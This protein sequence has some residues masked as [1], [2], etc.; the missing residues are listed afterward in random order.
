MHPE[1]IVFFAILLAVILLVPPLFER[2]RLPGLVG[3]LVAGVVLGPN[4]LGLLQ[5]DSETMSLLSDIGLVY[6][7]F[8]AGLEINLEQFQA[9]KNRSL[10]FG[11]FTFII[12]LI[13]G[14][15]VGRLFGFGLNASVLIGSLFAS[16]TLLAYPIVSRMGLINNEA[17]TVTIGATIFTDIA[18]LLVL[19]ICVGIHEGDFT[20][21]NLVALLLA[22]GIYS[23]VI[24]F[25]FGWLG[26]EF[27]RRS[28]DEEG[29]QFLFV[30][31]VVF[32]SALSA[33]LIGVEKIVGAFLAG[34]AVNS[35]IGEGPTEEKVIFVGN[36]LFIPIF[37]VDLGLLI[38]IPSFVKSLGAIWLTLAILIGLISSKFGAAYLM[39]LCFRYSW[40]ETLTMWSLSLPQVAATL[41]AT[42]VGYRVGLL[43]EDVLNGVI[44]LMLVTATL[45]PLITTRSAAKLSPGK[46]LLES[47]TALLDWDLETQGSPLTIMVPVYNPQT[48]RNLIDMAAL[49]V[50]GQ[51]GK[52]VP[53]A[54]TSG[55]SYMDDPELSHELVR[56]EELLINA[57]AISH[58]LGVEATPLLRIDDSIPLGISRASREQ[59]ANLVVIGWG[60][61]TGIRA[62]LF[63][64]VIDSVLWASHCPVAV[65]RL[66]EP[67]HNIQRILVPIENLTHRAVRIIRF[68]EILAAANQAEVTLLHVCDRHATPERLAQL[69]DQLRE[70][71]HEVS[72]DSQFSIIITPTDHVAAAIVQASQQF[73]LVVLRSLRRRLG[74]GELAISSVTTEAVKHLKSSV[75]ILG[76]PHRHHTGLLLGNQRAIGE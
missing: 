21:L 29:K 2:L 7:M 18:A 30:L 26:R 35:A 41:A 57:V 24:L 20:P 44:V 46:P 66:L 32:V 10:S 76:E 71:A 15:I 52:I 53:L 47:D 58:E 3:L 1:P 9:T 45:G 17:V 36:V 51:S 27:F 61:T 50:R 43:T 38:D 54:V 65:T 33:E 8:V 28:G 64:N 12:P 23:A 73:D 37:F 16:H 5:S 72:P 49:L 74:I 6:L 22:L 63:G 39:K 40:A 25:G 59:N 70:L 55:Y 34:L 69:E 4:G 13:V 60:K 62:R 67:P 11:F 48:E 19:A 75:V 14:I 31:L 56:S 68:A 42:L